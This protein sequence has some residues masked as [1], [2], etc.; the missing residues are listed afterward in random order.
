LRSRQAQVTV[1]VGPEVESAVPQITQDD[2][3]GAR[4]VMCPMLAMAAAKASRRIQ[5]RQKLMVL[6]AERGSL[7]DIPA[8]SWGQRRRAARLGGG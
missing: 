8:W 4:D 3:V 5:P 1:F 7:S 6:A 2:H